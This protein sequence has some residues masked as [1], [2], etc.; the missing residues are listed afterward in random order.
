MSGSKSTTYRPAKGGAKPARPTRD[1]AAGAGIAQKEP[2]ATTALPATKPQK[3]D[4]FT[5]NS[6]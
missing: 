5:G 6:D 1:P 3:F 2:K 4:K